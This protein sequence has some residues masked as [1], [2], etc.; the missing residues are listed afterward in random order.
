M[1]A[2]LVFI[3]LLCCPLRAEIKKEVFGPSS[4]FTKQSLIEEKF[5]NEYSVICPRAVHK[6]L[7][8][9][10]YTSFGVV[11][12]VDHKC[13]KIKVIEFYQ[14]TT[15]AELDEKIAARKRLGVEQK[16]K[17]VIAQAR[18]ATP[19]PATTPA[20]TASVVE[21]KELVGGTG[22][23]ILFT[24]DAVVTDSAKAFGTI[25][26]QRGQ[27]SALKEQ[28]GK[29]TEELEALKNKPLTTIPE[30]DAELV[31]ANTVLQQQVVE[32]SD[33]LT[34]ATAEKVKSDAG[35]AKALLLTENKVASVY[36]RYIYGIICGFVVILIVIML[37]IHSREMKK[38]MRE[39]GCSRSIT[40]PLRTP[41]S[42]ALLD[43]DQMRPRQARPLNADGEVKPSTEG[44]DVT[45]PVIRLTTPITTPP[46]KS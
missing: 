45:L 21:N 19:P 28:V 33:K 9:L 36:T 23:R 42:D 5:G 13:N 15:L 22:D 26:G 8:S 10:S 3:G 17:T 7:K 44:V 18:T 46:S 29:L 30:P 25:L 1:I 37:L 40:M 43:K 38:A 39:A 20:S 12:D 14:A 11:L 41:M 16:E 27:I 32:L 31:K 24:Y 4:T 35:H 34:K 6:N 2:V